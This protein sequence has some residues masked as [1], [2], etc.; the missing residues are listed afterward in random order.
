MIVQLVIFQLKNHFDPTKKFS[1]TDIIKM[2]KFLIDKIY[3]M[4]SGH[5]FQQ[6][7]GI[8]MGTNCAP[9]FAEL[10]FYTYEADFIHGLLK[11][12]EKKLAQSFNFTFHY[13]DDILSLTNSGFGDFVYRIELEKQDTTDTDRSA[14]YLDIYLAID[15][16]G[17]LR[18]KLYDKKDDFNFPIVNFPF[19]CSNI[20]AASAYGVFQSLWFLSGFPWKSVAA[21]KEATE[22]RVPSG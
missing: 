4:F 7:V 14:S 19:I 17:R 21:N 12:K 6:T 9:P 2:L 3:V 20:S 10:F 5:V 18:T 1:E 22:P 11:K 16:E 15:C 13:I 8:S